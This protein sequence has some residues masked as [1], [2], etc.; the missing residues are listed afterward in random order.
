MDYEI[1]C[2][3]FNDESC[4]CDFSVFLILFFY[5]DIFLNIFYTKI[6]LDLSKFNNII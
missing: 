3:I 6:L 1:I 5:F 4:F 2:S